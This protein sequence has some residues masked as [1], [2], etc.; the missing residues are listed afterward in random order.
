MGKQWTIIH[1]M[2]KLCC[3]RVLPKGGPA[4]LS[5][6]ESWLTFENSVRGQDCSLWTCSQPSVH[7]LLCLSPTQNFVQPYQ[8]NTLEIHSVT[9]SS[10]VFQ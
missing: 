5:M 3:Y 7:Q 2:Y 6:N 10:S 8:Y 9:C 1:P 4:F